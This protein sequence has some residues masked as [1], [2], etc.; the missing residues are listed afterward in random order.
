MLAR[1]VLRMAEDACSRKLQ[2]RRAEGEA[3]MS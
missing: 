3:V 1:S 2:A